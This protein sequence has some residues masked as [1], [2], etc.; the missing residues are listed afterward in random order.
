MR[1]AGAHRGELGDE[2]SHVGALRRE[3]AV[4]QRAQ[5][6]VPQ[7]LAQGRAR[8]GGRRADHELGG[9]AR[10]EGLHGG[11]IDVLAEQQGV[12]RRRDAEAVMLQQR[13]LVTI[14]GMHDCRH[15]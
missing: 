3:R 2:G 11:H 10:G 6:A 9:G 4:E 5:H 13:H 14:L 7:R 1:V 12:D 8:H 15:P